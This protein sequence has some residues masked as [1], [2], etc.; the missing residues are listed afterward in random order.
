MTPAAFLLIPWPRADW[1]AWVW[2]AAVE[3]MWGH[4]YGVWCER[5]GHE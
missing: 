1:H 4:W 3:Q 5:M 2:D